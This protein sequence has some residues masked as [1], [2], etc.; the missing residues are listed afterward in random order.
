MSTQ[1][2][3]H[4]GL[5]LS[6]RRARGSWLG[7][8]TLA[9]AGVLAGAGV[10]YGVW[11]Q[12]AQPAHQLAAAAQDR[13]RLEQQLGQLGLTMRV[14]EAR[15]QELEHQIDTLIQRLRECQEEL[16]FSRKARDS[17]R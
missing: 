17:K 7:R 14:S 9:A 12:P 6:A 13:T 10:G 15:S 5:V 2:L 1:D 8:S 16:T 11:G 4:V 3:T